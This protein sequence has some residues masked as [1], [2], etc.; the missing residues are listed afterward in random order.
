MLERTWSRR[1]AHALLLRMQNV[2]ASVDDSLVASYTT[3]H[4]LTIPSS[5][6]VPWYLSKALK[7]CIYTKTCTQCNVYSSFTHNLQNLGTTRRGI[8]K[9]NCGIAI[10]RSVTQH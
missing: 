9:I 3:K 6:H 5:N 10:Q 1:N 7:T 4:T 2:K 8:D